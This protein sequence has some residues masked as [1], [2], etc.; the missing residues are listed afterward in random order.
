[1]EILK[2]NA[3]AGEH[4]KTNALVGDRIKPNDAQIGQSKLNKTTK[5]F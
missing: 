2:T 5:T 1:M 4:I 3:L